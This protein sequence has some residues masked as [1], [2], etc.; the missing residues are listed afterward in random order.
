MSEQIQID[1]HYRRLVELGQRVAAIE[2][3]VDFMLRELK[4]EYHE[5]DDWSQPNDEIQKLLRANRKIEAIKVYRERHGVGLA[6]AKAAVERIEMG[7]TG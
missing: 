1:D 7:L 6:E 5:P 4:L 3:K 2:R